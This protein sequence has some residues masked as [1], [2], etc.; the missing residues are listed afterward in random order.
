MKY[1]EKIGE[2]ITEEEKKANKKKDVK[3]ERI[4]TIIIGVL[5]CCLAVSATSGAIVR[6]VKGEEPDTAVPG[7]V[8]SLASLSFMYFLWHYKLKAAKICNSKTLE[9]DA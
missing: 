9:A 4:S 7:L 6:L 3:A 8:V 2:E 5:L 1:K